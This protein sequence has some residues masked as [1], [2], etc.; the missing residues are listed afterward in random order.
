MKNSMR[1]APVSFG[2]ALGILWGLGMLLIG[3]AGWLWGYGI[4]W[5]QV[6]GSV[7]L[8][9]GPSFMGGIVGAV[10]GFIDFFIFGWL[11]ALIYNLCARCVKKQDTSEK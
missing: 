4:P 8:G 6:W 3:W 9:F 10:W 1:L 11:I 5:I 7:Y 2:F